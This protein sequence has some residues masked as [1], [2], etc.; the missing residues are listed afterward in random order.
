[1]TP[2]AIVTGAQ[3]GIGAATAIGLANDGFD[4]VIGYLDDEAAAEAV[5]ETVRGAGRKA[6]S[7]RADIADTSAADGLVEAAHDRFRRIDV[8]VNHA[9]VFPRSTFL[10]M[11]PEEWDLVLVTTCAAPPSPRRPS[12][13]TWWTTR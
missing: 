11:R 13:G 12:R 3:Q 6:V 1:M 8:L 5:A 9:G 7:V 10:E 4:L 2:V